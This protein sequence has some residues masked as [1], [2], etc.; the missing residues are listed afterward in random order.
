MTSPQTGPYSQPATRV[1]F[2][3][4]FGFLDSGHL[5]DSS[6]FLSFFIFAF[7]G[8]TFC[9]DSSLRTGSSLLNGIYF[10]FLA[11]PHV[12]INLLPLFFRDIS[13]VLYFDSGLVFEV[14]RR[15]L[16][17]FLCSDL[18]RAFLPVYRPP[19]VQFL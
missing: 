16:S 3:I 8:F 1:P 12:G 18:L 9:C 14:F 5:E 13:S 17:F 2:I 15:I 10:P 4:S 11:R 6:F 19:F 7:L